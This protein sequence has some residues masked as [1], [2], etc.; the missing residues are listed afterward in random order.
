MRLEDILS[1]AAGK[2][3]KTEESPPRYSLVDILCIVTGYSQAN[4]SHTYL[5][6]QRLHQL[7]EFGRVKFPGQGQRLTQVCT[8]DEAQQI[9]ARLGGKTA[10]EFRATGKTSKRTRGPTHD[11]LYVMKYS[12]DDTAV[13]I[14]RSDNVKRRKHSLEAGQN[15]FMEVVAIFPG[16][17]CL[18]K[19]VHRNLQDYRSTSG[20]GTEWFNICAEDAAAICSNTLK[21]VTQACA[22]NGPKSQCLVLSKRAEVAED[23]PNP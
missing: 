23:A 2:V 13:K 9:L 22:L 12:F 7:E 10:A 6:V 1:G 20:A 16:K 3:R 14:G 18:E 21:E 15:F 4:A 19:E 11:D 8:A 5:R 17:G